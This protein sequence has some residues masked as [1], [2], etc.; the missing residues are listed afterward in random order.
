MDTSY[1]R[2]LERLERRADAL[3]NNPAPT[4]PIYDLAPKVPHWLAVLTSSGIGYTLDDYTPTLFNHFADNQT[5]IWARVTLRNDS[6]WTQSFAA[7]PLFVLGLKEWVED[8]AYYG[9]WWR[10]GGFTIWTEQ[11]GSGNCARAEPW[12]T[13]ISTSTPTG[14]RETVGNTAGTGSEQYDIHV[15]YQGATGAFSGRESLWYT[16]A[17]HN[18][19]KRYDQTWKIASDAGHPASGGYTG[20][21]AISIFN[22]YGDTGAFVQSDGQGYVY[23]GEISVGTSQGAGD[24]MAEEIFPNQWGAFT[25]DVGDLT[26]MQESFHITTSPP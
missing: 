1:M 16:E 8:Q 22:H 20:I 18:G 23:M 13:S 25:L 21:Q 2:R 15:Q 24:I 3:A 14:F 12:N 9:D 6:G 17:Y 5:D 19:S 10:A 11:S 26:T 7:W 4:L